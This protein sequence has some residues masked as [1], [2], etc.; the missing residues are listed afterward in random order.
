MKRALI[1]AACV[2]P[3]IASQPALGSDPVILFPDPD[4]AFEGFLGPA[5]VV[6][7]DGDGLLD[8]VASGNGTVQVATNLGGGR[9]ASPV[10]YDAGPKG[11][12]VHFADFDNDGENDFVVTINFNDPPWG[13]IGVLRG[14]GGGT[15][16][17][18][19]LTET[20]LQASGFRSADL[21]ND[22]D[23]DLVGVS[24]TLPDGDI[25]VFLNDGNANF[26]SHF[27]IDA[28]VAGI[29]IGDINLDGLPDLVGTDY[30]NNAMVV[31]KNVGHGL[32]DEA[33]SVAISASSIG[34]I[35]PAALDDLDGDGDL[36]AAVVDYDAHTVVLLS[37]LGEFAFEVTGVIEF[38][39]GA[40]PVNVVTA[41]VNDD[42]AADLIVSGDITPGGDGLAVY[43]GVGDGT[44][45]L[46]GHYDG[47]HYLADTLGD[48]DGD[49][50]PDVVYDG[51]Q[52]RL[53]RGDGSLACTIPAQAPFAIHATDL[54]GDDLPEVVVGVSG[55]PRIDILPSPT[56]AAFK[57][58][59]SFSVPFGIN[60]IESSDVNG[61]GLRDLI[62]A[63][64]ADDQ[65]GIHLQSENGPFESTFHATNDEPVFAL[66]TDLDGDGDIDLAVANERLGPDDNGGVTALTNSGQGGFEASAPM[67]IQGR[68][69][70]VASADVFADGVPD[71]IVA[72]TSFYQVPGTLTI[73]D[74]LPGGGYASRFTSQFPCFAVFTDDLNG[75]GTPDIVAVG[76]D[77]VRVILN[78]GHGIWLPESD[79][80]IE[81]HTR[82]N[83]FLSADAA[84]INR[85]GHMDIVISAGHRCHT[86]LGNGASG[87]TQGLSYA[88]GSSPRGV[89]AADLDSD[90][91]PDIVFS[92]YADVT[93]L[94]NRVIEPAD[95]IAAD[96]NADGQVDSLDLNLVLTGF[97]CVGA[98]VGDTNA[99]GATNV[100]DLQ[101]VLQL[102]G[103]P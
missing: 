71:L 13:M 46:L 19:E 30:V 102:F 50:D 14:Q 101:K 45:E 82:G 95:F 67:G 6:D 15:F 18:P 57:G 81:V 3:H 86:V 88:A 42:D 87:F 79:Y 69:A 17:P 7:V 80:A 92:N 28:F 34:V 83:Q 59:A 75:D 56:G 76:E 85:D 58:C 103:Q 52:I 73:F 16:A 53:N 20:N 36:D 94:F 44:F 40:E 31:W 90:G 96:L 84:D 61:D 5:L 9:L 47:P 4:F 63:H 62:T 93:L 99:D 91:D 21:D 25:R 49:G 27:N 23:I 60:A 11:G 72:A 55:E 78:Y 43:L 51:S 12:G 97:G 74:G 38:E 41:R 35:Q 39:A 10:S 68:A 37:N 54:D 66:A 70:Y 8:V 64:R 89:D 98:C 48:L 26:T 24:E 65:V 22:G 100:E 33:S 29:T 1:A 32:F 77:A 2:Y